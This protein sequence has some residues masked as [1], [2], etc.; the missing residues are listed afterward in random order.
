MITHICLIIITISLI[1]IMVGLQAQLLRERIIDPK[2][3]NIHNMIYDLK[4]DHEK[5]N[6][7]LSQI[8]S[9]IKPLYGMQ[10]ITNESLKE[11]L[12]KKYL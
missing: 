10:K 4:K 5:T 8:L 1:L 9:E 6:L 2:I 3:E 7:L 12:T 11:I